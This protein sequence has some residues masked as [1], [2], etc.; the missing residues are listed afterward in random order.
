MGRASFVSLSEAVRSIKVYGP[1]ED[2]KIAEFKPGDFILTHGN[3]SVRLQ[4]D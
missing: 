4:A 2:A 3:S 1:G